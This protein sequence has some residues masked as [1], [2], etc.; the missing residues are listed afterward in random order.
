M[1]AHLRA[2]IAIFNAGG[3]HGAHDA[4][5][6]HWLELDPDTDDEQFLHGLIQYTAAVFHA[7]NRNWSGATGLAESGQEYLAG[8]T[9]DYR[10]VNVDEVRSFL[11]VLGR[12]PE[13]IE[14]RQPVSLRHGG[15]ELYP[16]DLGFE[17][18]AIA[19]TVLAEEREHHTEES[20][21][22]RDES[23]LIERAIQFARDD[24]ESSGSAFPPLLFDYVR[25]PADREIILQRLAEH[26]DLRVSR[27]ADVDGL[28]DP[29]ES[30][31]DDGR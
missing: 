7:T 22:A 13:V 2:G 31:S 8:L 27:E 19:A 5:E 18:T 14:R 26:V 17:A 1:K 4:W 20:H 28:F 12:D 24:I 25:E 15:K 3:H 6:E 29:R 9:G 21:L 30:E 23:E 10:D 11:D 16:E